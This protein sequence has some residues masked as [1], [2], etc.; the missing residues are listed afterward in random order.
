MHIWDNSRVWR[1]DWAWVKITLLVCVN[2][3]NVHT[4]IH[5]QKWS[6][7][8]V[9]VT[10]HLIVVNTQFNDF[11]ECRDGIL[12]TLHN[13][14]FNFIRWVKSTSYIWCLDAWCWYMKSLFAKLLQP[15]FMK[16]RKSPV[17]K[18]VL[19]FSCCLQTNVSKRCSY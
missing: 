13:T 1:R 9:I 5:S 4:C 7:R 16:L 8:Q 2:L 18:C 12:L 15:L 11:F 6:L 14:K 19:F 17:P 10:H 3:W